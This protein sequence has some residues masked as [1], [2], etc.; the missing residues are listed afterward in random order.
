MFVERLSKFT[1]KNNYTIA[2]LIGNYYQNYYNKYYKGEL[3]AEYYDER[4]NAKPK[5]V[6]WRNQ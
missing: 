6:D 4:R 2:D 3:E 5:S 1:G